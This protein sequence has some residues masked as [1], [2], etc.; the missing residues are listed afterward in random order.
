MKKRDL[1]KPVR[2]KA[3]VAKPDAEVEASE[4]TS[5][6]AETQEGDKNLSEAQQEQ[7]VSLEK[8]IAGAQKQFED[9]GR[10][11]HLINTDGLYKG[12]HQTFEIYCDVKWGIADKHAYRLINSYKAMKVLRDAKVG[13]DLL[14][15]NE[16]Q[17][18]VLLER[19][20]EEK[21]HEDWEKVI[22][23]ADK[24]PAAIKGSLVESTLGP[25]QGSSSPAKS[26]K[27]EVVGKVLKWIEER[28]ADWTA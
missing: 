1:K 9:V 27:K 19:S 25:E 6:P 7:L 22:K 11:L 10:A 5:S 2:T 16:Y 13:A 28:A 18:R 3:K 15:K 26:S 17:V 4:E 8:V 12:T 21:W 24:D 23:A 20:N 14:P